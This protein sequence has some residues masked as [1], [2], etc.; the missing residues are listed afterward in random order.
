MT[1]KNI[2]LISVVMSVYNAEKYLDESIQS[3][4]SQ[5]YSNFE[6]II[7]N[8][9]STDKSLKIIESYAKNDNRIVV[10]SRENKG[11]IASLNEGI[12]K[13]K[14]K[15]IA[16]MDADDISLPKRLDKQVNLMEA[17]PNVG[18]CGTAIKMFFDQEKEKVRRYPLTH[19]EIKTELLF[20][21]AFAHPT[22]MM[23]RELIEKHQ[24]FY[25]STFEHAE[26]FEL[27]TRFTEYTHMANLAEVLL[28]YRV[29]KTSVSHLADKEVETRYTIIKKIPMLYMKKLK[30]HRS[31]KQTRLH[32]N[33]GTNKRIKMNPSRF[34]ALHN[35]FLNLENANKT[36]GFFDKNVLRKVLARKWLV[37]LYYGR[38]IRLIFSKYT[39]FGVWNILK[40]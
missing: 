11:L 37:N 9:G 19:E 26:D 3:I 15:Y 18:I 14:G 36:I 28:K 40:K 34:E 25:N 24:L 22:V 32:F 5:T 23:R 16:R 6:F 30:I 10:I 4:L 7:I 13:A 1:I 33:L 31:E 35:Y 20:S 27:W 2:P 12:V 17:R 38:E 8:D 21:S 39:F 29:L